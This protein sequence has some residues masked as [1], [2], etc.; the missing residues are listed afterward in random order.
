MIKFEM[1]N[2][3][4]LRWQPFKP[5]LIEPCSKS[6]I[7][8]FA[9][10]QQNM[11][12]W[13]I[14]YQYE[15]QVQLALLHMVVSSGITGLRSSEYWY[16][17]WS[18]FLFCWLLFYIILQNGHTGYEKAWEIYYTLVISWW[19][20]VPHNSDAMDKYTPKAGKQDW[21]NW[22]KCSIS[23]NIII[24]YPNSTYLYWRIGIKTYCRI[25]FPCF[26]H[27]EEG[28]LMYAMY[29]YVYMYVYV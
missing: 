22:V 24:Q 17:R 8:S 5:A 13:C 18:P 2:W 15:S 6:I 12:A 9:E 10:K 19:C 29:V 11:T 23:S 4:S 16:S 27:F 25:K 20:G 28:I 21:G 3:S 1:C 14:I 7:L 26:L